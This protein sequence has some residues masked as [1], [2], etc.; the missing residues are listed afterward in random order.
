MVYDHYTM[1]YVQPIMSMNPIKFLRFS[2]LL[3]LLSLG[4]NLQIQAQAYRTTGGIRLGNYIGATVN[5]RILNKT[6]LEGIISS[7]LEQDGR[8]HL[9]IRQHSSIIF[10]RINLYAGLG[11]NISWYESEDNQW[12]VTGVAGFELTFF[13]FNVSFDYMPVYQQGEENTTRLNHTSALSIRYVIAKSSNQKIRKRKRNKRRRNRH[14]RKAE[15]GRSKL[16]F[17]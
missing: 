13:R 17:P 10:R 12:G 6:T 1:I 4:A 9:L 3:S 7:N 2:F 15:R 11:P 14:G 5:Q 8:A 16:K